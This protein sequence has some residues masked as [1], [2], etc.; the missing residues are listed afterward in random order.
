MHDQ[1]IASEKH[2]Q[3]LHATAKATAIAKSNK[4]RRKNTQNAQLEQVAKFW[5]RGPEELHSELRLVRPWRRGRLS[6]KSKAR[7]PVSVF[8]V[9]GVKSPEQK[10]VFDFGFIF[11]S[12]I[13]VLRKEA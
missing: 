11:V 8:F 5:G 6:S 3:R 1:C 12:S 7:D 10:Q 2:K 9:R 4:A 13:V